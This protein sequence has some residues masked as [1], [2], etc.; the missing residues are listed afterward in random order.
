MNY[1]MH[2][3]ALLLAL[4]PGLVGVEAGA[5]EAAE[6]N[7]AR[8]RFSYSLGLSL[9]TNI[10]RNGVDPAEVDLDLFVRG[11]R[12]ANGA[13]PLLNET[14]ARSAILAYQ[15]E[16]RQRMAA[17]NKATADEFLA[18]NKSKEGVVTTASGLQ[19]KILAEGAGNPP[20]AT[21]NVTVHYKGTLLDGT[22]FDSS[23]KRGQ[24]A[25]F[26]VTQVIKGWTEA[27]QLMKPGA[28]WQLFIPPN[29]A[30]GEQGR[31]GIPPNS[32]LIFEVEL[33]SV[34]TAAAAASPAPTQPITSDII[35]VPSKEELERG[36]KIE[37]I[38]A[39]DLEKLKQQ[40]AEKAKTRGEPR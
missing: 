25:T 22:E 6:L 34:Q 11:F 40:E 17:K 35:R 27:L 33:L 29:L 37:I 30:Y 21:D 15:T 5:A 13:S 7:D 3:R 32:L 18:A 4:L 2:T 39:S 20:K 8:A 23:Y 14:E 10:K 9:G 12:D 24:P 38:K 16:A 19:Y 28:K 1:R 31:P 36:A 26:G